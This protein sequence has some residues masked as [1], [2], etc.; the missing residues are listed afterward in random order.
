MGYYA[1]NPAYYVVWSNGILN[2][3]NIG[4]GIATYYPDFGGDGALNLKT[5]AYL[6]DNFQRDALFGWAIPSVFGGAYA[7]GPFPDGSSKMPP[8]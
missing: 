4:V 5:C 3:E 8:G 7:R 1:Q 6:W 2:F